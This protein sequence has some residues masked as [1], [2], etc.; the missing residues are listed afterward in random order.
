MRLTW[1]LI[2]ALLLLPLIAEAK[3]ASKAKAEVPEALQK[4]ETRYKQAGSLEALFEQEE[5]SKALGDTK[6]SQGKISW[7]APNRL[8]WETETP[9]PNL[10]VS[11]GKTV[12]FYTPPFDETEK[13]QVIIRK[14]SQL[15]N[16][17]I[18]ALLA[19]RFSAAVK[20]GLRIEV[21]PENRFK[22]LPRKGTVGGLKVAQVQIEPEKS[23]I[24]QVS[25]EY[26]DGN[27]SSI[28]LSS[29]ELGKAIPSESFSFKL[30]ARTDI[31]KE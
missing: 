12:W 21:L 6:K 9:D 4:V 20:Q 25:L 14:A 27:R 26:R 7:K 3:T 5:V 16:R 29:I 18:D 22:L 8:R 28:S 13:G 1:S 10:L 15:K 24:T 11:D 30:P 2:A 31:L 23:Q 17:L 19:G